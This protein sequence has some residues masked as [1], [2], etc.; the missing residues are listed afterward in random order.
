MSG[1]E[2]AVETERSMLDRLNRRYAV[3]SQGTSMRYVRAEHVKNGLGFNARR[4]CDFMALDLWPGGYG[5]D[6]TG[7]TL[8]GFEVKVSR[9]DWLTELRDPEKAESFARYCHHWWL[10]AAD[11][12]IVKD[13]LPEDW[14]LM[15]P[16]RNGGMRVVKQAPRREPEPLPLEI[17]GTLTRSVMKTTVRLAKHDLGDVAV[18]WVARGMLIPTAQRCKID[19]YCARPVGHE[20]CRAHA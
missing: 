18:D 5:P 3:V 1:A 16:G 11:R 19:R 9:S 7:A 2:G 15:V 13:D 12:S 6:R 8:H 10:A 17:V 20:V 4:T 14:G